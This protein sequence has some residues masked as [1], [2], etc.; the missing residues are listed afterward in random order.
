[1]P[2]S[3]M[4]P[5]RRVRTRSPGMA[6]SMLVPRILATETPTTSP[7]ALTTGP[8][9][10]PGSMPPLICTRSSVPNLSFFKLET[11]DSRAEFPF[12][13]LAAVNDDLNVLGRAIFGLEHAQDVGVGKQDV[14]F[15]A[16]EA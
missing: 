16:E 13:F 15:D 6:K 7:L 11:E 14:R 9:E 1:M 3:L 5:S 4:R 10:L 12:G 8:P 2:I